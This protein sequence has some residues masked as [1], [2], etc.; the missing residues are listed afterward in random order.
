MSGLTAARDANRRSVAEFVAHARGIDAAAWNREPAPGKWSPAQVTEHVA[1]AYERTRDLLKN[2]PTGG[3]PWFLRPLIRFF[4]V[5]PILRTGR[6][7]AN[8]KAP[9]QFRPTTST[10]SAD[11]LCRR[12]ESAATGLE[13]D[14][15]E[16]ASQ[17]RNAISHPIFGRTPLEDALHFQ[18]LHT[19]HH[20]PQ[21]TPHQP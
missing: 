4:Y 6:F 18:A 16:L 10:E 7:P 13:L 3:A 21:L 8:A 12:V 15:A 19:A 9:K 5:R 17:G 1:L 20:R 2:P 11:V 14:L